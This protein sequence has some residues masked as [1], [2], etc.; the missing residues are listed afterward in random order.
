MYVFKKLVAIVLD[1]TALE[2]ME[3]FCK[4]AELKKVVVA[5][6]SLKA[7]VQGGHGAG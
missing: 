5:F 4:A 2:Q 6:K 3:S 1:S 7:G